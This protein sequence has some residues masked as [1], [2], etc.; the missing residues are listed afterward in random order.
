M[1]FVGVGEHD[2]IV[3]LA[4]YLAVSADGG[5]AVDARQ[6]VDGGIFTYRYRAAQAA[7]LHHLGALTYIYRTTRGVERYAFG[8][9]SG[10][11][12]YEIAA[13]DHGACVADCLES[14]TCLAMVEIV[15][16]FFA[17]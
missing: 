10:L 2:R 17:A 1:G 12:V 16:Y 5:G 8:C 13:A 14:V 15:D 7:P 3:D 6:H 9:G 4:A 11:D